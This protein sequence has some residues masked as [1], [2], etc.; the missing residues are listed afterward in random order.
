MPLHV[1]QGLN[2][3]L[4]PI[5]FNRHSTKNFYESRAWTMSETTAKSIIGDYIF[6]HAPKADPAR[7]GG[8]IQDYYVDSNK[9]IVFIIECDTALRGTPPPNTSWKTNRRAWVI[10]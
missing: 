8:I 4:V 10:V 6:L 3:N 2:N 5:G 7:E 1:L 9:D